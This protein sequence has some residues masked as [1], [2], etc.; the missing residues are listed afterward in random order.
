MK[1]LFCR[2]SQ[3]ISVGTPKISSR[4]WRSRG[5]GSQG[6][7]IVSIEDMN[8]REKNLLMLKLIVIVMFLLVTHTLQVKEKPMAKVV[9]NRRP[10]SPWVNDAIN[11]AQ[12]EMR[13]AYSLDCA[14]ILDDLLNLNG[15]IKEIWP[16]V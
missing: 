3:G 8:K 10:A 4:L 12:L 6:M 2:P 16:D 11:R 5:F 14:K 7:E 1:S 15:C 13:T 9:P